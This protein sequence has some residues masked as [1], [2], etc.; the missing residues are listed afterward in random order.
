MIMYQ[1][2]INNTSSVGKVYIFIIKGKLMSDFEEFNESLNYFDQ[3][4][5]LF[6][7]NY[8]TYHNKG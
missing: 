2:T 7:K 1:M 4:I 8:Q 6:P 3:I 5:K